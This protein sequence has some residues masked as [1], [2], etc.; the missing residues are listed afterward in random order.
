MDGGGAWFFRSL[1]KAASGFQSLQFRLFE[2][3]FGVVRVRMKV[4][5]PLDALCASAVCMLTQHNSI[6]PMSDWSAASKS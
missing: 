2:N 6:S 3:K 5:L 1:L 4:F